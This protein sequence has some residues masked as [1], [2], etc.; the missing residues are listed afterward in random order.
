[1][2]ARHPGGRPLR[3]SEG[4]KGRLRGVCVCV[5]LKVDQVEVGGGEVGTQ[6]HVRVL[7]LSQDPPVELCA[8][9]VELHDVAGI[10]LDPE[11]VEL[12][13]QVTCREEKGGSDSRWITVRSQIPTC[14]CVCFLTVI[15]QNYSTYQLARLFLLAMYFCE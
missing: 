5:C 11:A 14:L 8:D 10:L 6:S 1:M 13:H 9:P 12:L 3:V 2:P 4:V 7:Q 15:L